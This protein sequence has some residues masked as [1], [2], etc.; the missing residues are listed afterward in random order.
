MDGILYVNSHTR[1]D[2]VDTGLENFANGRE[3]SH[4][5]IGNP[6]STARK[7][8][9]SDAMPR[10]QKE[11]TAVFNNTNSMGLIPFLKTCPALKGLKIDEYEEGDRTVKEVCDFVKQRHSF[12]FFYYLISTTLDEAA[13]K[14]T[15]RQFFDAAKTNRSFRFELKLN[16]PEYKRIIH[17]WGPAEGR[18]HYIGF[19]DYYSPFENY[20]ENSRLC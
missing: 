5:V 11:Y 14:K 8:L 7:M 17:R 12:D 1:E 16:N 6:Q 3:Y 10:R 2:I 13:L 15:I 19:D 20:S 4:L 9:L 18:L